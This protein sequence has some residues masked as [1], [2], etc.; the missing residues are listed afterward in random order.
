MRHTFLAI[1][2]LCLCSYANGQGTVC[3]KVF[4]GDLTVLAAVSVC[5]L[6]QRDSS[7]VQTVLTD[8][9]GC[10]RFEHISKGGYFVR[11]SL[12]GC[13][14][15]AKKIMI[16]N[17]SHITVDLCISE[18]IQLE[19]V[20]V[21]STGVTVNGDTTTY[22]VN[23]FTSGSER[24]LK[25]VLNRLPNVSV[26]ESSK[27]ITAN[28][29]RVNRIL[30]EGE[31][32]FQGNT[33][34][35]LE[36]LSADGMEKV[37]IIDNYSE[38]NLYD[39][40][41]T[42]NET[43]LNVGVDEK[44]KNA[45]KGEL[46]SCGGLLNKY[47]GRNS[48]LYIGRKSML[49]GIIASNNTG[50]RLLTFQDIMQFS[51]GIGNLISGDNPMDELSKKMA[52]YSAFT[53]SRRD[54]ARR[55]NSMASLNISA[56]PTKKVKLSIGCIYGYDHHHS[57]QEN[58]YSYLSGLNYT[59][60]AKESGCQHNG[61]LNIK[62]SYMPYKHLSMVYS[63]NILMAVQ[64]KENKIGLTGQ[65]DITF[66]AK[67]KT[68]YAKNSL[69]VAKRFGKN[70][71]SLSL[72]HSISQYKESTTF[73]ST[74]SY[75]P[76]S[77]CLDDSYRSRNK[78]RN[79]VFAAQLFYLHR[80]SDSYYLR[81]ALKGEADKQHFTTLHQ[82]RDSTAAYDNNLQIDYTTCYGDALLGK[83]RGDLSFALRLRYVLCHA[84]THI[85]RSFPQT[86]TSFPSPML[87]VKYQF[88]PFHHLMMSYEYSKKKTSINNLIDGQWLKSYNHV[89]YS[90]VSKLFSPSHKLSLSHLLS[91]PYAGLNF[92]NMASYEEVK[93]PIINHYWQEGFVNWTEKKQGSCERSFT[94]MSSAEYKFLNFPLNIRYHANYNYSYSPIYYSGTL[95]N[96]ALNSLTLTLQLV[97]F[98]KKGF[99]GNLKWQISNNAYTGVPLTNKLTTNNLTG[100]LSWQ[101]NKIYASIDAKLSTYNMNRT[102]T[103]NMYYSF[104]FRYKLADSIMLTLNGTDVMHLKERKQMTGSSS[105][106]HSTNS[107][108]W[109]MPGHI[110]A[111]IS[112]KY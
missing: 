46:E 60:E 11:A 97:T 28:G 108:T 35:P 90:C 20:A 98:Y 36:N 44:S 59:E 6:Q 74:Y 78:N 67:P 3:G 58:S 62:L 61:L 110:M 49:S 71:L 55:D 7:V 84:S 23:R 70:V 68:L 22:V 24:N 29:K 56:S 32:L 37:E 45:I 2:F 57:C 103:K 94:I 69:L 102:N 43:V 21:V 105:S 75:Y 66:G 95:Y 65:N 53:N 82:Q 87:Q 101:N 8:E 83:D 107:L 15:P 26:D 112:F 16:W 52:T 39:G 109:F 100:Q 4:D 17:D 85:K 89:E 13:N 27:T 48:S 81:F 30:L 9:K 99:N 47:N 5:L 106:Y 33:S 79:G 25:E 34:I 88:T 111:G 41:K 72:D 54:I 31:D 91:L 63:G 19:E 80:L 77:L 18:S 92:L 10:Y 51:G 1:A 64:D 12:F 14:S 42:T 96:A 73:E 50:D 86:S 40:F 76:P 104:V 38:Y 93:D